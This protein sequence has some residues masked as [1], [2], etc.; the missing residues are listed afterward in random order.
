MESDASADL[1]KGHGLIIATGGGAVLRPENV[2]ALRQN[3][4]II[5]LTR[6]VSVLS[7]DGRPLSKDIETLRAM[8]KARMPIYEAARGYYIR[9]RGKLFP[10]RN[11]SRGLSARLKELISATR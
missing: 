10:M 3:G 1:G 7:T 2:D 11:S 6:P 8:E 4:T 9:Q 5:H